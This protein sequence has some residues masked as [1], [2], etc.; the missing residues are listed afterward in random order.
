MASFG[1]IR[2]EGAAGA[3]RGRFACSVRGWAHAG[4]LR[5]RCIYRIRKAGLE[6]IACLAVDKK[7]PPCVGLHTDIC[8][9]RKELAGES[10]SPVI[11][12][13]NTV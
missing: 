1:L 9:A 13:L 2:R 4:G 3:G 12:G 10:N 8:G 6:Y 7:S 5:I 11:R